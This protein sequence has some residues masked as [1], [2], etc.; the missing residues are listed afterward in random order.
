LPLAKTPAGL[1]IHYEIEGDGSPL[2]LIGGTGHDHTFWS[3]TLPLLSV[4]YRCIAFDNRGVGRS[5]IMAPGFSLRAM[6]ED[7][8]AVLDALG[9]ARAHVMGFSMGGHIAQE[10][11]L[12]HA[13]RVFSLGIHHSWARNDPRLEGFQ[14]VRRR[15]AQLGEVEA[16]A[17]LSLFGIYGQTYYQTNLAEM[18][19]RR[20]RLI[21]ALPA[22]I[23]GWE[24]Q[25][26]ACL[27]GDT[28]DRLPAI[29]VPTLVTCSDG[30][31]IVA[32]HRSEEIHRQIAGSRYVLMRGGGH[33][34]L[35]ERP[36]EF[37]AICL[38]FLDELGSESS[39][40]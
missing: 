34:A 12:N 3:A 26:A 24:G 15:L 36:V 16:L 30:D 13:G 40:R 1:G 7:A 35:I 14:R 38:E 31:I 6:A 11:A 17:D 32:P 21:S 39:S 2:L 22:M 29:A 5:S 10:L 25:L 27:T 28:Y 19:E 9:I 20:R 18:A 4:R 23:R 33:V 37:A 8:V